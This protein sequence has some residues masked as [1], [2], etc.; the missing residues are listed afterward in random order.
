MLSLDVSSAFLKGGMDVDGREQRERVVDEGYAVSGVDQE[1]EGVWVC[2]GKGR[3]EKEEEEGE[4]KE[5]RSRGTLVVSSQCSSLELPNASPSSIELGQTELR[6]FDTRKVSTLAPLP[7][8]SS[9][10]VASI[11]PASCSTRQ[12]QSAP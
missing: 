12:G 5:G 6:A 3:E 4:E 9:L 7:P 10:I 8:S 2:I 1:V 11:H